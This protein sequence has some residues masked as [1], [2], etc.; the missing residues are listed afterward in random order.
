MKLNLPVTQV[1]NHFSSDRNILSTTNLKGAITYVNNDFIEVSGF[2]NDELIGKNHNM[3]RHPDMPPAAFDSLWSTAKSGN[4]WMGV[5]KNR[6]KDGNHYW[7][8]A[9]VTPI[10]HHGAVS[11]Y[12]SIRR[13][14]LPEHVKRAEDIYAAL[15]AGKTPQVL[16]NSLSLSGR[17]LAAFVI[18]A[19]V[20]ALS[21]FLF[22]LS[23]WTSLAVSLIAIACAVITHQWAFSPFKAVVAKAKSIIDN[24]VAR[25]IYTGRSDDVGQ[26]LLTIKALE[27]ETAGLIGR[28]ADSAESLTHNSLGLNT[29][30]SDSEAGVRQQ[31]AETD[32]VAAAVNEMSASIQEVSQNAQNSSEAAKEGLVQV[33]NGRQV[34]TDSAHSMQILTDEMLKA[35]EVIAVVAASSDSIAGI[36]DVIGGVADQTNLLALNAAIEA[37]RAGDAGRGFAVVADEVR[38]LASRTQIATEEIRTM[39]E[40]L[41]QSTKQ[42]VEVMQAGQKQTEVCMGHNLLTVE[43]LDNIYISI[44]N[45]ND[46]NTQIAAAVEQQS[47]VADEINRSVYKIRDLSEQNLETVDFSMKTSSEMLSLS[48]GFSALAEQFWTKQNS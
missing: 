7:V 18:P 11:E 15:Q 12:Q 5:V 22:S 21:V 36:L 35:S 44:E 32:Q 17:S 10:K 38:T 26:I 30:V 47:A 27:S 31:F 13:R 3:V 45:I 33:A 24:P 8:D 9:Y 42:A 2:N 41:Q 23:G 40:Q 19:S 6:T 39:I 4:S 16:K 43:S 1:E 14:P 28:I 37:A 25:F 46:M 29:L 34:V 20:A 48:N